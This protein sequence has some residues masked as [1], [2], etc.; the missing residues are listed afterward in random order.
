M[1]FAGRR[2]H[3]DVLIVLVVVLATALG[4]AVAVPS[5]ALAHPG[6]LDRSFGKSG[7]V[8]GQEAPLID[9]ANLPNGDIVVAGESRLHA[10]QP[11]GRSDRSFGIRGT[12]TPFAPEG[13]QVSIEGI[14]I[15]GHGRI[16]IAGGA[17]HTP[18]IASAGDATSYAAVE[19][20]LPNGKL[21]STFGGGGAVITDFG[22]P[23]PARPPKIPDY[24]KVSL[25]VDVNATG[26]AVDS[27]ERVVVTG[28]HA[29]TY[30][31]VGKAG[32]AALVPAPEAFVARLTASGNQDPAFN[33]TG[34]LSMPGLISLGRPALGPDG[35]VFFIATQD[36]TEFEEQPLAQFIG[37]LTAGGTPD[38]NFANG[39]WR[40]LP[41][42]TRFG[43]EFDSSITLDPQG[44]LL[45]FGQEHLG[46]RDGRLQPAKPRLG[47][48]I[49][50]FGANGSLDRTFGHNGITTLTSPKGKLSLGGLAVT[51]PG[52]ILVAARHLSEPTATG[53]RSS[54]L[55]LLRLT[56]DG[57]L[58]RGFGS[59]GGVTTSF[60][61]KAASE[62]QSVL[63]DTGGRAVVGGTASYGSRLPPR[64][65]LV[66]Y[67]LDRR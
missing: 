21:D 58:D 40:S 7:R 19:R 13:R 15:D 39:G 51:D 32:S 10:Y 43:S 34:T 35:S 6:A 28:R 23:L 9:M 50:R 26:I 48:S 31:A 3:I 61:R 54:R 57:R 37:H 41:V 67:L 11:N 44:R 14:A 2:H 17:E 62:G 64:F 36:E 16:V 18:G 65:V 12:V 46:A 24:A 52:R 22:F 30:Y 29:A 55:V 38:P 25:P 56:R 47:P 66:R 60:G 49:E 45:L 63:V 20:Y 5:A 59:A 4:T 33:G 42:D 1:S 8:I 27:R 53:E